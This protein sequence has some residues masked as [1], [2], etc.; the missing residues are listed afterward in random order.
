[1][2]LKL[3]QQIERTLGSDDHMLPKRFKSL[4]ELI[5]KTY[6]N[7][8]YKYANTKSTL[9]SISQEYKLTTTEFQQNVNYQESIL[10]NL[11]KAIISLDPGAVFNSPQTSYEEELNY[12]TN[13]LIELIEARKQ[14][15][16][17]LVERTN[18]LEVANQQL[19]TEKQNL[20]EA[21]AKDTAV[22]LAIG[23]GLIVTD[24]RQTII[25]IN[26]SFETMTGWKKDEIAGQ[27][28][29]QFL[30]T[31]S[32]DSKPN[33]FKQKIYAEVLTTAKKIENDP[34]E[35]LYYRRKD[36]SRFPVAISVAPIIM[37]GKIVGVVEVFKDITIEKAIDKAKGEFVSLASHQLRTPLSIINWH[38]ELLLEDPAVA[39]QQRDSMREIFDA[40]QRMSDLVNALLN[41]S[42]IELN[43]FAIEPTTLDISKETEVILDGF[44]TA[45]KEKGLQVAVQVG[46]G[47]NLNADCTILNLIL[48][49]LISNAI[50]YT[51][52]E[53]K[54]V[55]K[56]FK[57]IIN[58]TEKIVIEVSDDG[59]GIPED[60]KPKIF[61]KLFRAPNIIR[62]V[63]YGNGLDLYIAKSLIEIVGGEIIFESTEGKGSSFKIVL[64][65]EGMQRRD[66]NNT[67]KI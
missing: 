12:L 25:L 6:D 61:T 55:I 67:L 28:I 20:Q 41:I 24:E 2:N 65:A 43:S 32:E 23:N 17:A 36:G 53:G 13:F 14:A 52:K 59:F 27:P 62:H 51:K 8:D 4:L 42:R 66:N 39:S 35:T 40:S 33:D 29:T 34:E 21:E 44:Q 16:Y 18:Q 58:Q 15:E 31:E 57:W 49:A 63:T 3:A 45:I 26:Q 50:D 47:I 1:M 11:Q 38:S 9:D 10:D 19:N 48:K 5:S 56:G 64:P 7:Y 46:N 22:L 37:N 54:I 60:S 30:K